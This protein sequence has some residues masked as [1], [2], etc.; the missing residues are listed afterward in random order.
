MGIN[1][2]APVADTIASFETPELVAEMLLLAG[3]PCTFPGGT[4]NM[5]P[6]QRLA[7]MADFHSPYDVNKHNYT[8]QA[9]TP[10]LHTANAQ[11]DNTFTLE[12]HGAK[13]TCEIRT[14]LPDM[15]GW[16]KMEVDAVLIEV[17]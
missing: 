10:D 17:L 14:M 12:I 5:L 7:V 2:T 11:V 15:T 3:H 6:G 8:F 1:A 16:T 9:Y 13:L 4:I